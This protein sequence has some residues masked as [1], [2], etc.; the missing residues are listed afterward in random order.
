MAIRTDESASELEVVTEFDGGCSWIAHPEESMQRA[1]HA[2]AVDDE[3]WVIDPV[4]GDTLD[5]TLAAYGP[6]AGVV[7]GLDRHKRD[8][9]AIAKRH[10]VAVWL[11]DWFEGVAEDLDAPV[12]RFG[13]ELADTG[14]EAHV[15]VRNRFWQEVAL[16]DPGTETLVVPESVGTASYFLTG[17]ERLGVHP[18]LRLWPPRSRL[19]TF[20]PER[21][22]VGHGAGVETDASE[23]L[24]NALDGSRRH[25]PALYAS[26]LRDLLP[27]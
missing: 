24:R 20:D 21:V 9:A 6:V 1:S 14:I 23:A 26:V 16:F 18:V 12:E 2:I 8:A 4:D 25:A 15:V 7:V 3:V 13:A 17:D 19:S 10:D 22:L 27:V 5:D 11:P